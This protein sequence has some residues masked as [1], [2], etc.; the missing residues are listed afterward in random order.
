MCEIRQPRFT[1]GEQW[2]QWRGQVAGSCTYRYSEL[3]DV[4]R[5]HSR[6]TRDASDTSAGGAR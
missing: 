3:F 4:A 1:L 5:L 6:C 2:T